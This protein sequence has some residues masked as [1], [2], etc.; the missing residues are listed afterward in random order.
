M[1]KKNKTLTIVL[2]LVL[3][4]AIAAA[5]VL[6]T[7]PKTP[8]EPEKAAETAVT[9]TAA[10]ATEA[11]AETEAPE[12]TEAPAETEAPAA[13][14]APAETAAPEAGA[15]DEAAPALAAAASSDA[16]ESAPEAA[17]AEEPA[18]AE[19]AEPVQ[20][21]LLA[22]VNGTEIMSDNTDIQYWISYTMYQLANSGYDTT[23]PDLLT[24]VR[25]YAMQNTQRLVLIRNKAKELG[26]DTFTD[27]ETESMKADA[28]AEWEN[29]VAGY[30]DPS[31]TEDSSDDDKAAARADAEAKL[32]AEGYTEDLYVAEYV[33]SLT[34]NECIRRLRDHISEGVTVSDEDVQSHFDDLVKEDQETYSDI[35]AY[36]FYTQMYQ[37]PSYYTPEGYRGI[38]HILLSVD[39]ELLNTWKDLSARYEEQQSAGE[40]TEETAEATEETEAPAEETAEAAEETEAPAEETAEAAE[41]TAAPAEETAE[42][43]PTEAPTPTPEPVTKEMVDAAEK[44]ILDSVQ[45]KV[46]EINAKLKDGA[47]FADL[48]AEYGTDPGMKDENNLANGYPVHKDSV[49][50]DPAFTAGAMALEKIGDWSKPILGSYGVHILYYLRDIPAGAVE[51]TDEMKENFRTELL[52]EMKDEKLNTALDQWMSE[53]EIVYTED[54]ESWKM[55]EPAEEDAADSDEGAGESAEESTEAPAAEAKEEPAAESADETEETPAP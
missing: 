18:V 5:I 33:E 50:W 32:R 40:S 35:G 9:E 24:S 47:S 19:V 13:T 25:Q 39:E 23:S 27:E 22:T 2:C 29:I 37:Q 54:G 30:M 8:A 7:R 6:L 10:E 46:D 15:A 36:E 14:E 38:T 1:L 49:I 51:L 41:E 44:A 31:V 28:R 3:I 11:P 43:E 48:I 53:A 4:A 16:A 45:D 34:T 17:A 42:A 26:L 52:D 12:V 20:P 55:P 21:V